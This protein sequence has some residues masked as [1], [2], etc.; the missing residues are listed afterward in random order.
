MGVETGAY[1][2]YLRFLYI[3]VKLVKLRFRHIINNDDSRVG[4]SNRDF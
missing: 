4:I 1:V 3:S 2:H